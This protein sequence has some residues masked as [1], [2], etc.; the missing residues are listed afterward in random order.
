M[1]RMAPWLKAGGNHPPAPAFVKNGHGQ[2]QL[3]VPAPKPAQDSRVQIE[4]TS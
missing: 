2:R 3:P 1:G 4:A